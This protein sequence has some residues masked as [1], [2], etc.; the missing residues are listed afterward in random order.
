MTNVLL[1]DALALV[2]NYAEKN[3]PKYELAVRKYLAR[4]LEEER[5]SPEGVAATAGSFVERR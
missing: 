2:Y 5:P 1:E 4:W 3:D